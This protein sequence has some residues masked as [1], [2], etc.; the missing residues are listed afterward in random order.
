MVMAKLDQRVNLRIDTD[1]YEAYEK[2]AG[3]F[4]RTVPDVMRESLQMATPV[5]HTLGA[6]ID[7]AK[8][9]DGEA[10]QELFDA[11]FKMQR[12][13][14]DLVEM[15]TKSEMTGGLL[16]GEEAGRASNTSR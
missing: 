2:V 16:E 3:F 5:M 10:V 13:Q 1:T 12:G 15:V 14:L 4:N 11:F 6:I 9:G 7:R 8:A